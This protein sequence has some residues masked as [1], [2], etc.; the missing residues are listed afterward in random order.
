MVLGIVFKLSFNITLNINQAAVFPLLYSMVCI[1]VVGHF[2]WVC[3][4]GG[5]HKE[6][7]FLGVQS[8]LC[9]QHS[10]GDFVDERKYRMEEAFSL[11][12]IQILPFFA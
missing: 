12:S 6:F 9:I 11:I 8:M 4:R 7:H 1:L 10:L 5:I 2:L 3:L